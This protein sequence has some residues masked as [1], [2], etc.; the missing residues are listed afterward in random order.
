MKFHK[1]IFENKKAWLFYCEKIPYKED[2]Y[3]AICLNVSHGI[4]FTYSESEIE[5]AINTG[6]A[7]LI[8][9]CPMFGVK[10]PT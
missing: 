10:L 6:H 2:K 1:Q 9:K 5:E 3:R 7:T 8:G 4:W